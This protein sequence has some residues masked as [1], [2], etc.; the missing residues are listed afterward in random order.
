[1]KFLDEAKIFLKSGDG[2]NGCASFRREKYVEFGGPDGGDGGR[3]GDVVFETLESLNTLIDLRYRQ[4]FKAKRGNDGR[5]RNMTGADAPPVVIQVPAGTQVLDEARRDVLA[6]FVEVGQRHVFLRGGDGGFGN[7]RFKSSTN[8]APRR[9]DRGHPGQECWV[10]LRLK[11]LADAGLLGL[12]N[13]GKSTFL[14]A[15]SRAHPK[16]GDYPF[17]TLHPHL[18]VVSRGDDS[19]VLADIPGLIAGAHQG[20][21]LGDRFLGHIERCGV[22]LHL[23]DG[24]TADPVAAYRTVRAE[25]EAYGEGLPEKAEVVALNKCD[26]LTEEEAAEKAAALARETGDEVFRISA[27]G[28]RGLEPV[29]QR[30]FETVTRERQARRDRAPESWSSLP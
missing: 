20:S 5:G 16:I 30:L 7:S 3:G 11:L 4:H 14:A 15:V 10:W 29:L 17:T 27:A 18:G 28:D 12:P 9:A 1:M 25:V 21:G 19:F 2:G 13:A 6:D 8:R 26:G 24:L 23:V 22:L